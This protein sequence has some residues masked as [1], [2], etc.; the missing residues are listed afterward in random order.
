MEND[1]Q[2]GHWVTVEVTKSSVGK[3]FLKASLGLMYEGGYYG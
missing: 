2:V 1:M 3:P